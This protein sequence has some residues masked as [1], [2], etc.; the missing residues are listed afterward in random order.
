M[1][2]HENQMT[3]SGQPWLLNAWYQA[4]W[5]HEL[6]ESGSLVRTILDTPVLFYRTSDGSVAAIHD[7]CPHRF[8][9]L[10]A[11]HIADGVAICGYHG[12][13][14]DSAGAC[15]HNPHG[16]VTSAMRVRSFPT[17]VRHLAL[18]IWMGDPQ[19]ADASKIPDLSFIDQTPATARIFA[20]MPTAANYRLLT[21]NIMDLSHVDFLHPT[22]L[23]G[24]MLQA[25]A[26]S[27]EDGGRIVAEWLTVNCVAPEAYQPLVRSP[28]KADIWTQVTWAAPAVMILVTSAIPTGQ[29]RG[30]MDEFQ[31]VHSITPETP[32]KSHYFVCST[33]PV[34]TD[35]VEF[36]EMLRAALRTAFEGE[37]K[38]MLEKQ[39]ARMGTDD[40]WSLNPILLPIDAAAVRTRRKLDQL[41]ELEERSRQAP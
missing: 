23:G 24:T 33:R 21:D 25:K 36:T 11:G 9:P 38:P 15:V 39:Q 18:W 30:P 13:G 10:S 26:S 41:I 3:S 22:T 20:S 14:F 2:Q 16:P 40:L 28:E 8:A 37:D 5:A 7:R 31:T 34:M 27:R 12:L 35:S 1:T 17:E 32:T 6:D 29:V 19:L 4:G